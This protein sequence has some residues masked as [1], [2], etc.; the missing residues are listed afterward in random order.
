VAAV[1]GTIGSVY[2]VLVV[3]ALAVLFVVAAVAAGHGDLMAGPHPDQRPIDLPEAPLQPADLDGLRFGVGLRG[4]RMDQVDAV[5]D[6]VGAELAHRDERIAELTAHITA[7]KAIA[8]P[9]GG[10]RDE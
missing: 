3:A 6:R 8:G 1:S 7:L 2:P 9:P 10:V 4:Y 5:L